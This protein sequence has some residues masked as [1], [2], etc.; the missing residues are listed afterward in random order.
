MEEPVPMLARFRQPS[1]PDVELKR[2]VN[3]PRLSKR[4]IPLVAP[5]DE[6]FLFNPVPDMLVRPPLLGNCSRGTWF[7]TPVG[8]AGGVIVAD[9]DVDVIRKGVE[10]SSNGMEQ[11]AGIAAGEI[12]PR[13]ADVGLEERV[14]HKD[15]GPNQ[16]AYVVRGVPREVQ[17]P[18]DDVANGDCGTV[19]EE[20]VKD[21]IVFVGVDAVLGC[22]RVLHRGDERPDADGSK[23][24]ATA[25]E[26]LLQIPCGREVVRMRVGF[27][28]G[29]NVVTAVRDQ[30]E[31]PLCVGVGDGVG[32]GVVIEDRIDNNGVF[33]GRIR[34]NILPGAGIRFKDGVDYRLQFSISHGDGRFRRSGCWPEWK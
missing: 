1:P 7:G 13:R 5:G 26:G 16:V 31:E 17:N 9:V 34:D 32:G 30:G 20:A 25:E 6:L 21:A 2:L 8:T 15:V 11:S 10:L 33:G 4:R 18:A 3:Q 24:L 28:D 22:E 19:W 23:G 29:D 12:A 27:E 14:A